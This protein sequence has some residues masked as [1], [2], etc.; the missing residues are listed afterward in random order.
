M[1]Y[2]EDL[3]YSSEHEWVAVDGNRARVGIT[4]YAQDAL[5][6]VVF[7]S[8]PATGA[9]VAAASTCAEGESTKWVSDIYA[10]ARG[11]IVEVNTSSDDAHAQVNADPSGAGWIFVVELSA[12]SELGAL[13]DAAGYRALVEG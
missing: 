9:A 8:L 11:T 3:K 1:E 6:D 4:D 2:P 12:P 7:V 13:L 5:G 10:P